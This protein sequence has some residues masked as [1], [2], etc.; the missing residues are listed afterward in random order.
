[1]RSQTY[2]AQD[3]VE[4]LH[5]QTVA[6]LPEIK[7]VLGT[8]SGDT[9]HRKLAAVG[10]RTSYSHR[11]RYYTLNELTDYD[12]HGLWSYGD[13]HFSAHGTLLKTGEHIIDRSASGYYMDEFSRLVKLD[14]CHSLPQLVNAGRLTRE[15]IDGRYLYCSSDGKKRQ[16][17]LIARKV[18]GRQLAIAE[19][20]DRPDFKDMAG[21]FMSTLDEHQRRLF[22]GYEAVRQGY[23]GDR[24][25]A[26]FFNM[27]PHTVARG[28][29]ELLS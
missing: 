15:R 19:L 16:Q 3:I 8:T 14:A 26:E 6:T 18:A 4:L 11:G 1:M 29:K 10:G 24:Q 13:I 2:R 22:A 17:Q 20:P 21:T 12:E 23:D 28:R 27:D 25:V 9:A 7:A 5:Q